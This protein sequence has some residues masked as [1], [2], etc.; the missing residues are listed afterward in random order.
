MDRGDAAL[1]VLATVEGSARSIAGVPRQGQDDG[2]ERAAG[3]TL[4][5]ALFGHWTGARA[6]VSAASV[7]QPLPQGRYC[8]C[9]APSIRTGGSFEG[10][11][12][13]KHGQLQRRLA[14]FGQLSLQLQGAPCG[15]RDW[16]ENFVKIMR[17]QRARNQASSGSSFDWKRVHYDPTFHLWIDDLARVAQYLV[18]VQLLNGRP[19]R[20]CER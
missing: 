15:E 1:S 13:S 19:V 16:L 4:D 14:L 3:D 8:I 10:E 17:D 18:I 11:I 5:R 20:P 2:L 9:I 6:G 7:R 12:R